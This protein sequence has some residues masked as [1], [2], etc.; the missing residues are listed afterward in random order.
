GRPNNSGAG[1]INCLTFSPGQP[2]TIYVGAPAGGFWYTYN[3]GQTW[4][5]TTDFLP[6]LGVSAIVVHPY[7]P[8]IIYIGTGDRDAT[9]S[10]GIGVMKSTDGGLTWNPTGMSYGL[11]NNRRVNRMLIHPTNPD[12]V[13]AATSHGFFISYNGGQTWV[14]RRAGNYM[15][16]EFKPGNPNTIYLAS[17]S[18][19]Y[20]STNFG[21]TW[22]D[23]SNAAFNGFFPGRIAL[24][25]TPANPNVVYLLTCN[26][27]FQNNGFYALFKSSD[28]GTTWTMQSNSPNILGWSPTGADTDG[29]GW[30]DLDLAV[31]PFNENELYSGG[32]NIW[33][34]TNGGVNWEIKA[35]WSGWGAPYV[36]ADHHV[37][38]FQ[39]GTNILFS[40]NDGGVV[41]TE[42]G[43]NTWVD[44]SDGLT[45]MQFYRIATAQTNPNSI[46]GGSQD[47]GTNR[48]SS[49]GN[50]N[51][52]LGGDGMDCHIDPINSNIQY[53]S[54]YYGDFY[55]TLNNW[56]SSTNISVPQ[57]EGAWV[58][59]MAISPANPQTLFTAYENVY[60]SDNRGSTWTMIGQFGGFKFTLLAVA[61]MDE[62]YIY[63]GKENLLYRTTDGG[64]SWTNITNGIP[65]A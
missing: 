34:S 56:N 43:G 9:D 31:S 13:L 17:K 21:Q 8:S 37:L 2:D 33:K 6:T 40:G 15:D 50:W 14:N 23:L 47:N 41:Y 18:K 3:R 20:R 5:T 12:T 64:S 51:R 1:R 52:V 39:P 28:G 65:T 11:E 26:S 30:Y 4:Q 19:I 42:D 7:N 24:S 25:V 38:E 35:H 46:L 55:R 49:P 59:P 61:E 60:R 36:H 32:V 22:T 58:T 44:I 29:Q 27:G 45:I 63:A 57:E 53:A 10:Y 62:N 16:V 48:R 54:L